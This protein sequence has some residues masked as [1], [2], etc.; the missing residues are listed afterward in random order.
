MKQKL[1]ELKE[2]ENLVIRGDNSVSTITRTNRQKINE[3][4]E[5]KLRYKPTRPIK[6]KKRRGKK[7]PPL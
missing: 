2:I 3:E 5:D 4:I 6:C 1:T 7:E